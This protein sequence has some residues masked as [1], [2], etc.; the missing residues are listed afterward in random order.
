[1]MRIRIMQT[2]CVLLRTVLLCGVERK[3]RVMVNLHLIIFGI[4]RFLY[5][6][7]NTCLSVSYEHQSAYNTR[8]DME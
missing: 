6:I 4:I 3:E 5:Y 2:A 8:K 7:C 1:M